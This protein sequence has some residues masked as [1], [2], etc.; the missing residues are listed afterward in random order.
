MSELFKLPDNFSWNQLKDSYKKLAIQNHPDKGGDPDFF[1]FITQEFQ[2]LAIQIKNRNSNK[3]HFDL[4]QNHKESISL[5]NRFGIS[6][7]AN[8]TF[9]TKFNT[10]F[11]QNKFVDED[12]EFGY[13][14]IM[15]PSSKVREDINITNVFGKSTVSSQTFNNTF[16]TKV[17][18]STNIIKY[19]E[20]EALP[21]CT[22]IIH[23]EIGNKT[24][25]YSGKTSSNNLSYTDFKVAFTEVRTPDD[26]NRKEFKTV[27]EY[28]QYSDRKL[29]KGMTEKELLFKKKQ[30]IIEDK[31]EKERLSRIAERDKK[32]EE[33]YEKISRL[34]IGM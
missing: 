10:I 6:Q 2:K 26:I 27:K 15:Q 24:T 5:S 20:P 29:K 13:G 23:S 21:S 3:S 33:Y 32:L 16:N 19:K 7:V 31:R 34:G 22:K 12:I 4:K 17:K 14:N 25:D 28:Q 30:E 9:S 1:N 11:D 8:D 18:P